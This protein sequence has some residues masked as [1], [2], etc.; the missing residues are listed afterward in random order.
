MTKP[1]YPFF[2]LVLLICISQVQAQ[3]P[4]YTSGKQAREKH[5]FL[6]LGLSGNWLLRQL[7]PAG[8]SARLPGSSPYLVTARWGRDNWAIRMGAGGNYSRKEIQLEGF[9]DKEIYYQNSVH[10]RLGFEKRY[11]IGK[12]LVANLGLDAHASYQ[13]DEEIVDSGFDRVTFASR[14]KGLGL[15]PVLGLSYFFS[16][17]FACFAEG[18]VQGRFSQ[19]ETARLFKNFPQ[20]DDEIQQT[21]HAEVQVLLPATFYLAFFF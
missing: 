17:R 6:E 2:T 14:E 1:F 12:K 13:N 7:I 19:S 11:R 15:G 21:N 9:G 8:D 3:I 4:E 5:H 16:E 10:L 18:S 20:F